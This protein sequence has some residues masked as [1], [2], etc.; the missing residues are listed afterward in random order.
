MSHNH[1]ISTFRDRLSSE[2]SRVPVGLVLHH[3][4]KVDCR[5]FG[6]RDVVHILD[7]SFQRLIDTVMLWCS[8]YCA[9]PCPPE[10]N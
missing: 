2:R 3:V 9:F 5:L 8:I 6:D 4:F 1:S 10:L 7:P